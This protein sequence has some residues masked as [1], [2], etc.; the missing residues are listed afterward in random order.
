MIAN[1]V[2]LEG[3]TIKLTEHTLWVGETDRVRETLSEMQN[4]AEGCGYRIAVINEEDWL[5]KVDRRRRKLA[6]MNARGWTESLET[7]RPLKPII[8]TVDLDELTDA[9]TLVIEYILKGGK[10]AGIFVHAM[11]GTGERLSHPNGQYKELFHEWVALPDGTRCFRHEDTFESLKGRAFAFPSDSILT[12]GT[13]PDGY[14][15]IDVEATPFIFI[16]GQGGFGGT[17]ACR[18]LA[19][20]AALLGW[21]VKRFDGRN[22]TIAQ[23]KMCL[24]EVA[25]RKG[26]GKRLIV[27][28]DCS[29]NSAAID[30]ILRAPAA[31]LNN[32]A[33][34][35][36]TQQMTRCPLHGA[37]T[38]VELQKRGIGTIRNS[39]GIQPV[40]V[41][42][43]PHYLPSRTASDFI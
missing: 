26:S 7:D 4:V 20:S 31:K 8:L 41:M 2:L 28:D 15:N 18:A 19:K 29:E 38:Y 35:L 36:R 21:D 37:V 5:A 11:N 34:I 43:T 40:R 39:A 22:N 16:S 1:S 13:G 23:L 3:R 14:A 9:E 6:K 10:S 32:T 24:D 12:L 27:A 42:W 25:P 30:Y 17:T 33:V